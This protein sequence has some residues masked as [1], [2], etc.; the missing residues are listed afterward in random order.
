MPDYES[1]KQR[2]DAIGQ[3][4]VLRFYPE[5]PEPGRQALLSQL[6]RLPLEGIPELVERYVRNKPDLSVPGPLEPV[7]Y[8]SK[9]PGAARRPWDRER[10][11]REGEALLRSGK[12][13]AF[14]VAGGQ[15]SRLGYE[16]PKGCFP[17][18]AVSGKP[19]F[20]IF[21]EGLLAAGRKYGRPVP[22]YIMTSPL[23]HDATVGFFREHD[24]FG[25]EAGDVMFFR[26][27]TVPSF[28]MET[29]LMLMAEKD[30]VATNPDGHGGS[31][32]ALHGS[33]ALD[34]MARR[35]VEQI[36]YFHVDNPLVNVADPVFIG[37]HAAAPDSSGEMS[38]KMVPKAYP[39][40]R[41]GVFALAGGR[42]R[43]IEY[44]DL[45]A[46]L[47]EQRD[48]D[49][50]LRFVAGSIGVHVI[51]VEFVRRLAT[52]PAFALPWHRA[53]KKV[54]FVD[55]GTGRRVDPDRPNAVKLEKFVFDALALCR[56]SIV[57]ETD[58]IEEFAPIKNATGA[59]SVESSREIQTERAARWLEA[60]GVAVPRTPEGKPD[61]VLEISPLTALSPEDLAR[62]KPAPVAPGERR[63]I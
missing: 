2:L 44:S 53:E 55:T 1:I 58:R 61:C 29:G 12:V 32:K 57:Y 28:A 42:T 18:G 4:H 45:P 62:A 8:Y 21:A 40:E 60:A 16:G 31:I 26:Q 36:S 59:D 25:L 14:T 63:V 52:D 15:G 41:M 54:P 20:Q 22:W 56:S 19:L 13:A 7:P 48:E 35:G 47:A 50:S 51:S 11:R 6:E 27:G 24:H 39:A 17:G 3:S 34:D 9:D 33:G 49:G 43:V 46:E 37:L 38:S 30:Q 5:L 23:N 10:Y